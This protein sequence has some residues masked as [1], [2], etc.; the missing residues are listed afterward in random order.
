MRQD[1]IFKEFGNNRITG[2]P[3]WYFFDP[4][5][6][7]ICGNENPPMLAWRRGVYFS[8]E[9]QSPLLERGFD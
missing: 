4:F 1:I 7:I 2:L 5:G 8:N 6:K 3:S 9:V